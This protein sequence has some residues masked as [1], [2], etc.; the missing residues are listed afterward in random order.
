MCNFH[1][2][3]DHDTLSTFQALLLGLLQDLLNTVRVA[4]NAGPGSTRDCVR[5]RGRALEGIARRTHAAHF[6]VISESGVLTICPSTAGRE[7]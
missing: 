2:S 5:Y 3:T 6:E 1:L 4:G 7:S